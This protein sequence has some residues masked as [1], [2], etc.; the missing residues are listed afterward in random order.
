MALQERPCP[1]DHRP[2]L[3]DDSRLIIDVSM[4]LRTLAKLNY[5]AHTDA[6]R[7]NLIP[8]LAHAAQAASTHDAKR[9]S[10]SGPIGEAARPDVEQRVS[11]PNESYSRTERRGAT[12]RHPRGLQTL[13]CDVGNAMGLSRAGRVEVFSSADK[14]Q[15]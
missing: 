7:A 4:P 11:T 9:E 2:A 8:A 5:R 13:E 6:V 15:V 12:L 1:K 3:M 10:A 14:V